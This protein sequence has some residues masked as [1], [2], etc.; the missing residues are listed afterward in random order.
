MGVLLSQQAAAQSSNPAARYSKTPMGY[1]IVLR[2]GDQV[3][4]ELEKFA[5]A[6]KIPSASIQGQGF[7]KVE[8]GYWNAKTKKFDPKTFEGEL[9][10]LTGSI[11][12]KDGK[13]SIHAHGVVA[14]ADFVAYAGHILKAQ[15]GTGSL[16]IFVNVNDKKLERFVD[17]AIEANVLSVDGSKK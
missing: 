2:Q 14:G 6:E 8:F 1:L 7:V 13:P 17:P 15:V 16:E 9:S 5:A 10:G 4:E 3:V 12:W 11:A